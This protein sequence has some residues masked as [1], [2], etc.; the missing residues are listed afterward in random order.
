MT[1]DVTILMI[2]RYRG[3]KSASILLWLYHGIKKGS[4]NKQ[5]P[6]EQSVLNYIDHNPLWCI[7]TRTPV[8]SIGVH[9]ARCLHNKRAWLITTNKVQLILMKIPP[10]LRL[11]KPLQH[12]SQLYG[13]ILVSP[14]QKTLKDRG[15]R[16]DNGPCPSTATLQCQTTRDPSP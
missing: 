8:E 10:K 4:N 12:L 13:S 2:L 1:R 16:T 15:W 14:C 6:V 11:F 7:V 9:A 3:C 5:A